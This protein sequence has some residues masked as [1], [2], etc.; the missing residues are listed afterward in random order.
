MAS[1]QVE[2]GYIEIAHEIAVALMRTNLSA[3]QS[4]IIWA[5]WRKTWGWHKKEDWISN[6]QFVD[7]TGISKG[8]VARTIKELT[9]RNIV[10]NSG[11]KIA[12]NKDYTRWCELPKGVRVYQ[13]VTNSGSIVTPLGNEVTHSDNKVTPSGVHKINSTKE[14][15]QKKLSQKK[16]GIPYQEIIDYLNQKTAKKFTL[17]SRATIGHI[18]ARWDE[19]HTLEDFKT[20]VNNKCL[21]WL[22]N[23]EMAVYL[24]PETLFG[25]K[26][27]SYLNEIMHPMVGAVS[28]TTMRNIAILQEWRPP[29]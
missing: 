21:S 9:M 8:H 10:T 17:K 24:R 19:G 25:S 26:F 6:S 16:Y 22:T 11:K 15:L 23:P 18:N 13:A 12:F 28:E 20:V 7:M 29:T 4:R 27:E 1:P 3:Y 14:T 5:L 2:N